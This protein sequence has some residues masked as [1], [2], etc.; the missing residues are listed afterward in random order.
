MC[1]QDVKYIWYGMTYRELRDILKEGIKFRQ[2]SM[3]FSPTQIISV[4]ST[5]L[6][7]D[8]YIRFLQNLTIL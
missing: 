6:P 3:D 7:G 4:S 8:S 1:L 2:V 5:A